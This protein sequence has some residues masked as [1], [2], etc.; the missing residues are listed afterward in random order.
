MEIIPLTF[1]MAKEQPPQVPEEVEELLYIEATTHSWLAT[2]RQRINTE[3]NH[4]KSPQV[5]MAMP[6]LKA[7]KKNR[8]HAGKAPKCLLPKR[9]A[10]TPLLYFQQGKVS[11]LPHAPGYHLLPRICLGC[12]YHTA[13]CRTA[14]KAQAH[15]ADWPSTEALPQGAHSSWGG[16]LPQ[17]LRAWLAGAL[18]RQFGERSPFQAQL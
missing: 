13:A 1:P 15:T 6:A 5:H 17:G 12:N 9:D 3:E 10:N 16:P 7:G 14:P 18:T 4:R 11:G 8:T 2:C